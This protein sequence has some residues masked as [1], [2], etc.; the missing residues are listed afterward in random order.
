MRTQAPVYAAGLFSNSM[1][2][3]AAI[4]LPLWLAGMGVSPAA[5]GIVIGAKHILP[6]LL[7]IHGGALM[8]K[9]G[10]RRLMVV[11]ALISAG[12]ALC[13]PLT[14]WVPIIFA[15]QMLNGFGSTIGFLG[16]QTAFAQVLKGS[17][18]FAGRFAFCMRMGGLLGPPIAGLVFDHLGIW[19]AFV[20]LSAWAIGMA[21]AAFLM[22]QPKLENPLASVKFAMIDL[23]PKW[24]DYAS[25]FRLATLPAVSIM[26]VITVIRISSSAVQD[27]FYP[28]YL[29]ESG[30]SATQIGFL[31]TIS[32]AFA[33][34]ASLCVTTAI[35]FMKPLWVLLLA[36]VGS[37]IFVAVTP[38]LHSFGMLAMTSGLRGFCM[39]IS[40]PLILSILVHAAGPGSQG[41]TIALRTTANRAAA[42]LTPMGMG[43]VAASAGLGASFFVVGGVLMTFCALT[44]I[45]MRN[46]PELTD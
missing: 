12:V 29:N 10:A 20:F 33:A 31:V 22:P 16:A 17:H 34:I 46:R 38:L 24:S 7:A 6:F 21:I 44:A 3:V 2:D 1:S 37:I 26:L 13:F 41:K 19:G 45:Y 42:G 11:C 23:M 8:D 15:L 14:S 9:L 4:V 39:G 25:A 5:I 30:F 32:A 18:K 28:L 36:T 43:L 35:R 27:S 40:Q